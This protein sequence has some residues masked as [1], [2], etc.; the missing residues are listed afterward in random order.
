LK[1][2]IMKKQNKIVGLLNTAFSKLEHSVG[3]IIKIA[4]A[5]AVVVCAVLIGKKLSEP[6]SEI[7]SSTVMITAL[8]G[9]SGGSGVIVAVQGNFSYILTNKHVC[10]VVAEGGVVK[11]A[12]GTQH[13]V[14][15]Y[16]PADSHDLCVITVSGHLPGKVTLASEAPKMYEKAIVSGHPALLPNVVTEGH[17]SGT[18][19]I[20]VFLGVR[21]CTEK[22]LKDPNLGF[23][24]IFLDGLPI[25]QTYEA[26]LVTAT[27]MPG[28]SG[29]AIYTGN[30]ELGA[31]VFAGSGDIGYAFAVPYEYVANFL[32]DEAPYI[33]PRHPSYI[34]N[35]TTKKL[36][37]T[38]RERVKKAITKCGTLDTVVD[39]VQREQVEKICNT[40]TGD[41]VGKLL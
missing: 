11:T 33:A 26:V 22:E 6:K 7:T 15:E 24:C 2:K 1:G 8:N 34:M 19:I 16:R 39:T 36:E 9:S 12:A 37:S 32:K 31:V 21:K 5:V 3:P 4:V 25:I 35:G 40:I 17:F 29:S 20:N 41:S 28:S 10:G 27:I 18:R 23:A 30:K 14:I 13:M 38:N